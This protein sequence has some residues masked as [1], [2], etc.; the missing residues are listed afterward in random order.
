MLR[1]LIATLTIA[2]VFFTTQPVAASDT[3]RQ[4]CDPLLDLKGDLL[5]LCLADV[6]YT[7]KLSLSAGFDAITKWLK[8]DA[9][10]SA[11]KALGASR[12]LEGVLQR[13]ENRDIRDCIGDYRKTLLTCVRETIAICESDRFPPELTLQMAMEF[14]DPQSSFFDQNRVVFGVKSPPRFKNERMSELENGWYGEYFA[15]PS[16]R[17]KYHAF[18]TRAVRDG[19]SPPREKRLKTEVCLNRAPSAPGPGLPVVYLNC[20]E[21]AE[22]NFDEL[23]PG[24]VA[25]CPQRRGDLGRERQFFPSLVGIANAAQE[26]SDMDV[27]YVPSLQTLRERQNKEDLRGV[28]FVEFRIRAE[29]VTSINADGVSAD[30]FVNGQRVLIDGLEPEFLVEPFNARFGLIYRFALQTLNFSG[31]YGGC[32]L[33]TTRFDF[34]RDGKKVHDPITITIPHVA[35]RNA[36]KKRADVYSQGHKFKWDAKY[37]TPSNAFEREVFVSSVL[38]PDWNQER[39]TK[40][41]KTMEK[42]QKKFDALELTFEKR[43]LRGVIRPPLRKPSFGLAVAVIEKSGQLRFTFPKDEAVRLRNYLLSLRKERPE[44]Q[45]V[46]RPD[47]FIY[48][49]KGNPSGAEMPNVC[50]HLERRYTRS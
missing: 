23:D 13:D 39:L 19:F 34:Y 48:R 6:N 29:S 25:F 8:G 50:A 16:V 14:D 15:T 17:G 47:T 42:A 11:G 10:V 2:A 5:D 26:Q 35:L 43:K 37:R 20:R 38:A 41:Q 18:V 7:A 9:S 44:L 46:I 45:G 31:R 36:A 21:G 24:W 27:W 30:I 4:R 1:W 49:V 28:G 33:V 40:F 12:E 3:C 22:C 32:D